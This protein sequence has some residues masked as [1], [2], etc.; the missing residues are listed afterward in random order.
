MK[1]I[2]DFIK[3]EAGAYIIFGVLTT[4]VNYIVFTLFSLL[5]GYD[6]VLISNTVAFIASVAFAYVTNKLF[7]FQN[8]SFELKTL[9]REILLFLSARIFSYIVEQ[10]SLYFSTAVLHLEEYS[11][12]FVDGVMAAKLFLNILVIIL[13]WIFSKFFIFKK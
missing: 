6:K 10:I 13:N 5:L 12:W 2:I 3:G 11:L 4:A 1:R 8:K 7:V 9:I